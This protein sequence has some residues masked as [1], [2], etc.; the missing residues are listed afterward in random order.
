MDKHI[1]KNTPESLHYK[2]TYIYS[3]NY[4]TLLKKIYAVGSYATFSQFKALYKKENPSLSDGYINKKCS[5]ILKELEKYNFI[6]VAY[7]NNNKFFYFKKAA[8]AIFTGDYNKT[9]KLNHRINMKNNKFLISLMKLEYYITSDIVI[10]LSNLNYH[11][12]SITR[13]IYSATKKYKLDYDLKDIEYILSTNDYSD[14]KERLI[15]YAPDNI[16]KIIWF[17][18]Y[19]IYRKLLL[20]HQTVLLKP[21]Y[22][23]LF[24]VNKTLRIHYVPNII[25]FDFHDN[26]YY[27]NKINKLFHDFFNINTN[28]TTNIRS[29]FM[30]LGTLGFK[31]NNN[32]GYSFTLVGNIE[33]SLMDK[34][35]FIN[36][37]LKDNNNIHTP[38]VDN[39]DYIYVNISKYLNHS[40]SSKRNII[41]DSTD[42][43][44]HTKLKIL[45]TN[46]N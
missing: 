32:I 27:E 23:K 21:K 24:I 46:N 11:L 3:K 37:L 19:N 17:D 12:T 22:F 10:S 6:E 13:K 31:H 42:N 43:Y 9:P 41:I 14:I 2:Y 34:V 20:Q 18:L 25:I 33:S 8:F 28:V 35:L 5:N 26:K 4:D 16:L 39:V 40:S 30:A 44:V 15:N 1:P 38:L 29:N 7:L 45:L 36:T